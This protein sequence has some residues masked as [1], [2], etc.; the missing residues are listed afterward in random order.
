[1]G[2]N[3][4]IGMPRGSVLRIDDGAGVLVRVHEGDLW[5]TLDGRSED[6]MLRS[7][8]CFVIGNGGAALAQCFRRS[9]VS[10][11][12]PGEALQAR[13]VT[14]APPRAARPVVL[15]RRSRLQPLLA[16]FSQL[17]APLRTA[18]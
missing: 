12:S 8:E 5:L 3:G 17:V 13:R 15:H 11:S 2:R 18:A 10:L 7:G 9:V 14:L 6:H 4:L 1:M 16:W